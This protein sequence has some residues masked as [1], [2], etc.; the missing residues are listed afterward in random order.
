MAKKIGAID[1]MNNEQIKVE[2]LEGLDNK[3][4]SEMIAQ[5]FATVSQQYLPIDVSALPCYR[6]SQ[7]PPDVEEFSVYQKIN[8]LKN[9][10]STF[11]IDLPNKVRK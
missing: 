10:K 8:K 11:D 4:C 2:E 3:T 5:S 1:Q 9:T 7:K 6:P